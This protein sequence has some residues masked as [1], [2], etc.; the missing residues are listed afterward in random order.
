M[1]NISKFKR[2]IT[3]FKR[4]TK[5]T[6]Q[7]HLD[8]LGDDPIIYSKRLTGLGPHLKDNNIYIYIDHS[9]LVVVCLDNCAYKNELVDEDSYNDSPPLYFTETSHRISPVWQ[10][11][12][13]MQLIR[14][15]LQES[16]ICRDIWGVLLTGS[17]LINAD[18]EKEGWKGKNVTVIDKLENLS[19]WTIGLN[20]DDDILDGTMVMEAIKDMVKQPEPNIEEEEFAKL[21]DKFINEPFHTIEDQEEDDSQEETDSA[22]E[23]TKD[24]V[25]GEESEDHEKEKK[26]EDEEGED[27]DSDD[28]DLPSGYIEQNNNL[29]VQVKILPPTKNPRAELDKLVGCQDI[30]KH[31]DELLA[32]T[33]YNMMVRRAFPEAKIHEVSLHSIFFGRPGTGKT[34]VCKIFGSLLHEAGA[35]SKGHVVV[36]DRGTFLG[37]LW[38]DEERSVSQVLE[39]ARGGVLMIDEA[40]LL[41]SNNEHDPGRMV[42]PLLMQVLADES[43][44]NIAVVLCGYKEPMMQLLEINPG[45]HSRFPNRFEF[46]DFSIEDLMEITR[47][48]VEEYQYHFTRQAWQKYRNVLTAAYQVRDP[49]TWGNARFVSNQLERIFIQHAKRC[50]KK[51]PAKSNQ[52]LTLT[53]ADIIPIEVPRPKSRIGF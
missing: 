24:K 23:N 1:R 18:D 36:A 38:G 14:Q 21:L 48:R 43:Q 34:T 19:D 29:T 20:T 6:I 42:I 8:T 39:I 35:L 12:E 30:K 44:R 47:R 51:E 3:G 5:L 2:L 28:F 10:L 41:N 40:Y 15:R 46:N 49:Q 13:T 26:S 25:Q 9:C 52:L 17:N 4:Q 27:E 16:D 31:I 33:R 7:S 32:L 45:L 50:V 37:T 22:E 53:P 11:T